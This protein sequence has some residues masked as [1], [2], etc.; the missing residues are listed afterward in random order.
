MTLDLCQ[1]TQALVAAGEGIALL[2]RLMLKPRHPGVAVRPLEVDTPIRRIS[3]LRLPSRHL[4]A[5]CARFLELLSA[6]RAAHETPA[7]PPAA[8]SI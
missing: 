6:T 5:P 4:T 1:M 3:A 7:R 2:P 8:R